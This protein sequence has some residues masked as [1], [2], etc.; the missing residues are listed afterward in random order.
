MPAALKRAVQADAPEEDLPAGRCAR[1]LELFGTV[2]D[3]RDRRGVRH[4]VPAVPA[5]LAIAVAA[6]LAGCKSVLAI[7]QW[8][9]AADQRTLAA[10]GARR[11]RWRRQH[12]GP[13]LATFRRVLASIDAAAV[14]VV[15]GIFLAE[16]ADAG[17]VTAGA[18]PAPGAGGESGAPAASV[19]A[20]GGG[21]GAGLERPLRG[22]ISADGKSVRGAVQPDGRCVHLLTAMI[23]GTGAIVAQRDVEH[24]TNELTQLKP[25]L[26]DLDLRG[27]AVTL[28]ALFVQ[29]NIAR[30]LAGEKGAA[31]VFTAAKG[32]QPTLFAK[33]DALPWHDVPVSYATEERGHGRHEV[34]TIQVMDAPEGIWPH[35]A[36]VFLKTGNRSAVAALGLTS[37]TAAQAGPQRLHE[38]VRGHWGQESRHWIRDTA[39]SEDASKLRTGSAPQILAGLRN[40]AVGALRASGHTHIAAALWQC[41]WDPRHALTVLG[42]T[43]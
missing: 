35:A 20:A 30:W 29:R 14:D 10:L 38:L 28:D 6:T 22:A 7:A 27:W 34:R 5:V 9:A 33:L 18:G 40:L 31:Y 11:C 25:L 26:G 12:V 21:P 4:P 17:D 15:I 8:A 39:W 37:A 19:P 42:V 16:L 1:L 24:K 13:H 3:P 43:E 36:Q 32:N 23:H 41:A 2:P